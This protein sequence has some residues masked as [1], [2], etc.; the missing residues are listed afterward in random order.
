MPTHKLDHDW[1]LIAR[2]GENA[3]VINTGQ[4]VADFGG[5]AGARA[6]R[7]PPGGQYVVSDLRSDLYARSSEPKAEVVT[8]ITPGMPRDL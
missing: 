5:P 6:G 1:K 2:V 8:N 4:A 7:I 3:T